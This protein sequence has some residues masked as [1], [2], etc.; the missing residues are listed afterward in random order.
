MKRSTNK[1]FAAFNTAFAEALH[2]AGVQPS[3]PLP[4]HPET[5]EYTVETK[6][7]K[8]TCHISPNLTDIESK[9]LNFCSVMGR[10]EEPARAHKHVDCN[11]YTGKWNF[12]GNGYIATEEQA[13]ELA[14]NIATR[15]LKLRV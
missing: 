10:F 14:Q 1:V 3:G 8:Y 4:W 11:P 5:P 12:D 9:P 13:R 7:G 2:T 15:I 6:A